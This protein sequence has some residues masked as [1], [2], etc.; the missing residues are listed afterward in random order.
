MS[1]L[2]VRQNGTKLQGGKLGQ[3]VR[4]ELRPNIE[5][6]LRGAPSHRDPKTPKKQLFL[7][8]TKQ[9]RFHILR[10]SSIL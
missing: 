2:I 6:A 8:Q 5:P 10:K 1:L 9:L 3:I 4:E 7:Y